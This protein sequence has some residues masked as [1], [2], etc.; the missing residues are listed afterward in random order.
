MGMMV[1]DYRKNQ[2][3]RGTRDYLPQEAQARRWL[4]GRLLSLL[5]SW[6][7][8]EIITPTYEFHAA[9]AVPQDEA[10]EEQMIKF[11]DGEGHLLALRPDMT[12]PM[13][14]VVATRLRGREP[15]RLAYNAQVFRYGGTQRGRQREFG[16]IGAELIGSQGPD[17]DGEIAAL[18]YFTLQEAGLAGIRLD[19]GHVEYFHGLMEETDLTKDL[20]RQIRGALLQRNYVELRSLVDPLPIH[21]RLREHLLMLPRLRGG[22]KFLQGVETFA[23]PRCRRAV[24]ELEEIYAILVDYGIEGGVAVDLGLVKDLDYYTGMVLEAY[25]ED[26]GAA[27]CTG[28]RYDELIGRFGYRTCATGFALG[29]DRLLSVLEHQGR[30]PQGGEEPITI[31]YGPKER[32]TALEVAQILRRRGHSVVVER[33]EGPAL[34]VDGVPVEGREGALALFD[35]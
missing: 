3:P 1:V 15:L 13:A 25:T 10:L 33:G 9:L 5:A 19:L 16:Q 2:T 14:R 22:S 4:E 27:L 35:V 8:R 26:V 28:G 30:L 31:T 23:N 11:F 20:Q 34:A 7:Y 6:G 18:A 12:T 17:A 24:E 29:T 21:P 32:P